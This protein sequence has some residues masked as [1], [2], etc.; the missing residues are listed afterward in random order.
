M[1]EKSLQLSEKGSSGS[2]PVKRLG[3]VGAMRLFLVIVVAL[4]FIG[5]SLYFFLS[6]TSPFRKKTALVVAVVAPLTGTWSMEGREMIRGVQLACN[7]INRKGGLEGRSIELRVFDDE[8][9]AKKAMDIALQIVADRKILLVLGHYSS[10]ITLP[11]GKIYSPHGIPAITASATSGQIKNSLDWYFQTVPDNDLI[12]TC[13]ANFIKD[14]LGRDRASLIYTTGSYGSTLAKAFLKTAREINL[15]IVGEWS[16]RSNEYD[17]EGMDEALKRRI[18]S[19]LRAMKDPGVIFFAVPGN[20]GEW[21]VSSINYPG[22]PYVLI[23]ADEFTTPSFIHGFKKYPQEETAPGYFTNGVY[24]VSPFLIALGNE[25]GSRFRDL[26]ISEYGEE[27]WWLSGSYYDAMIVGAEA[28]INAEI[29][30][31]GQIRRDRLE[32]KEALRKISNPQ[33]AVQGIKG[34]IYFGPDGDARDIVPAIGLYDKLLFV[35]AYVQYRFRTPQET[36]QN[37]MEQVLYGGMIEGNGKLMGKTNVVLVE[38]G[39]N[40]VTELDV[41]QGTYRIDFL[42]KFRYKGEF[43]TTDISFVNAVDPVELGD[44]ILKKEE[45]GVKTAIY[46]AEGLFRSPFNFREYPLDQQKLWIRFRHKNLSWDDLIYVAG[47]SKMLVNDRVVAQN[48]ALLEPV[49][50]WSVKDVRYFQNVLSHQ[51]LYRS[52]RDVPDFHEIESLTRY[53]QF[54]AC[55]QIA[56]HGTGIILRSFVPP[57]VLALLLY[58]VYFIPQG[59][60]GLRVLVTIGILCATVVFHFTLNKV[61]SLEYISLAEETVLVLYALLTVAFATTIL[62]AVF[63]TRG[64]FQTARAVVFSGRIAHPLI[65]VLGVLWVLWTGFWLS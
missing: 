57:F 56:R 18:V 13:I 36:S 32:I 16:I 45:E 51:Q 63:E 37:A 33:H 47:P 38:M 26:Y 41:L 59:R 35:P 62:S 9:D 48:G 7:E 42:L 46:H 23:G 30:D 21:L 19:Q 64:S 1:G 27:P 50:G 61:M 39:I 6:P 34:P 3:N 54:N 31:E 58:M 20:V 14:V 28:I 43:D 49:S 29:K 4:V 2:P 22:A 40:K 15:Q 60:V 11:V 44:P 52:G 17:E 10:A 24:A 12:G 65:V 5:L 8:N 55:L 53:S 25:K